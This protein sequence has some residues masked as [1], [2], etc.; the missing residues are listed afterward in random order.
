[1]KNR[2][3]LIAAILL[4]FFVLASCAPAQPKTTPTPSPAATPTPA[5]T[6]TET[7]GEDNTGDEQGDTG[8]KSTPEGL[9]DGVYTGRSDEDE[10]GNYGEIKITIADGKIT[11]AEYIEYTSDG[12]EKSKENGY[13]YEEALK[14]FEDLPKKLIET[15]NVDEVDDYSGATGT[16]NKFRTAAKRALGGSP[17][18]A[19]NGE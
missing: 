5:P 6:P 11:E 19:G 13:E 3:S 1:M 14:A 4:V 9:E 7:A 10:R 15:Q 16:S 2:L 12:K 17:E 8:E 18:N